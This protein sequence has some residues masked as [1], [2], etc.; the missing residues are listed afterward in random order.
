[1]IGLKKVVS[2]IRK[3]KNS[4][5]KG[6]TKI[7]FV[8]SIIPR[9]DDEKGDLKKRIKWCQSELG[10]SDDDRLIIHRYDSLAFVNQAV[11]T[12]ERSGTSLAQEYRKLA[13]AEIQ[14]QRDELQ[15][16]NLHADFR[17]R[18]PP[19]ENAPPLP[20]ARFRHSIF[21]IS[22]ERYSPTRALSSTLRWHSAC[23]LS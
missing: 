14:S 2:D 6:E 21:T 5:R 16:L 8:T 13:A 23:F 7:V 15:V 18:F 20:P 4:P 12:V 1:M 22:R 9:I 19:N 10:Y 3:E 11:F 17:P